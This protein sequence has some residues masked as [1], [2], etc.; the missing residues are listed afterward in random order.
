MERVIEYE[1][2]IVDLLK[3]YAEKWDQTGDGVKSQIIVDTKGKHYQLVR[4]GWKD[5]VEY[6]HNCVFHFDI[7]GE[8]IWVQEN[9][10]DI[11]VAEELVKAGIERNNIVLGLLPPS[12]RAD[13]EYAIA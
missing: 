2:I 8:K 12:L 11:L 7:I 3:E 6:I 5:N 10:T 1:K 13:S 9:R 4:I